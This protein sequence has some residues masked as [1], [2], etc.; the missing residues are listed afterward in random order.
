[1]SLAGLI[2]LNPWL[3]TALGALPAIYW[4]LRTVPPSP[5][6][7][8][9]PPTRL[10]IG[11]E[12]TE[13]TPSKTPWWLILIRLIAAALLI[14]GFS[15]P[16][17]RQ[18]DT[19]IFKG[20]G[21]VIILVDNSWSASTFWPE[22]IKM[23]NHLIDKAETENRPIAILNTAL[24]SKTASLSIG[25]SSDARREIS[26]L[27]PQP[28]APE[29]LVTLETLKRGL[30]QSKMANPSII[31][32]TDGLDHDGKSDSFL[33]ALQDLTQSGD[34]E[35]VDV[36]KG[37]EP[38]GLTSYVGSEGKIV[39]KVLGTGRGI[40][41]GKVA[42][43][44]SKNQRLAEASFKIA[45][46]E[47][48]ALADFSLPLELRNQITRVEIE[49]IRSAGTVNLLDQRSQWQR[50]GLISGEQQEKTQPLLGP[51]YYIQRALNPFCELII[52]N[53]K[54]LDLGLNQIINDKANIIML[55]DIGTIVGETEKKLKDWVE[56]GGILVRFA[57]PKLEKG[58]DS[59]LPV[60]LRTGG[61]SLGGTMSWSTPQPLSSFE[62]GSVFS[63]LVVP[64]DVLIKRQV[65]ADPAQLQTEVKIWAR[66]KDGT[67]LV[68]SSGFGDGQIV[69]FHITANSEWSNLPMSGLFVEMLR[70][71][72]ELGSPVNSTQKNDDN[73]KKSG[74]EKNTPPI[75]VVKENFQEVLP[76]LSTL[77]G[78]GTLKNPPPTALPIQASGAIKAKSSFDHP[79]GY[80]GKVGSP[81][82]LN[83]LTPSSALKNL[84]YSP[85]NI[86]RLAY[87]TE[88]GSVFIKPWAL[89]AA[90][91]FLLIDMVLIFFLIGAFKS[92]KPKFATSSFFYLLCSFCLLFEIS[93]A[94]AEEEN[95][96]NSPNIENQEFNSFEGQSKKTG[97]SPQDVIAM[98]ATSKVTIGYILT[99]NTSVDTTSQQ[100]L[101]G[102]ARV[103]QA[104]TAVD[105]GEPRGID[106]I[107]DEISF[108][109]VL[110]WPVLDSAQ[111]LPETTLSKIDGY[112]KQGGM[113][114]FDTRDYEN[115]LPS[116]VV[117]AGDNGPL[118]QRL[119]GR[120]DIPRLEPVPENHVLTKSFY[121]MHSFPGRWEGG[122]LWVEAQDDNQNDPNTTLE[123]RRAKQADG[124]TSILI[125][126]NDF[127]SAWALDES[128]RPLYPVV[129]GGEEQ[130][131]L[132]FRAGINI[133]MHALTGNYKADQVHVPAL[134]ERLGQ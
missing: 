111:T 26:A 107:N 131:E 37:K 23:I 57:G 64:S 34:L 116:G 127:A 28:Y 98:S 73:Q 46:G 121:I 90:L 15:E 74:A 54:N 79:P 119:I 82:V 50:V 112:M 89:L 35:I 56:K 120:L 106:I 70:R 83:I 3:L 31:W 38:L 52:P 118:L 97:F 39:A 16:V 110:Y 27:T 101:S 122:Q 62:E 80:Y 25:T 59:L 71:I 123:T 4:L 67:P 60:G 84:P 92:L 68:T 99:G 125:S 100:G 13:K 66:L 58:G 21:P 36:P 96:E 81:H 6:Q 117:M 87:D 41:E 5:Q 75:Q 7:I 9:F 133:V 108:Y 134:L 88:E 29:R 40:R 42:A 12:N 53:E 132:A 102:L 19:I 86:S 103:L 65:L 72:I 85:D 95:F 126:S 24:I 77:D 45:K 49:D 105:P 61:R 69:L 33:S 32:L 113:I 115:G 93:A 2:F 91:S 78:F 114:I 18:Q 47:K 124:V 129:P 1:M 17:F 20:R 22:C 48:D 94:R 44:S 130:R 76:P 14:I 55:A 8:S 128:G 51:T 43:Y 109:P 10:L 30:E 11:L 104:R 63:G